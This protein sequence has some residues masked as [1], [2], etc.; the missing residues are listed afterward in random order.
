MIIT[1]FCCRVVVVIT[2]TVGFMRVN[3]F[4][5]F[6]WCCN[7]VA[8]FFC[9][10]IVQNP[11]AYYNCSVPFCFF[12]F[13]DKIC[14][15][16]SVTLERTRTFQVNWNLLHWNSKSKENKKKKRE[17]KQN[18][19]CWISGLTWWLVDCS[20]RGVDGWVVCLVFR[21]CL[22][23]SIQFGVCFRIWNPEA[24]RSFRKWR[25]NRERNQILWCRD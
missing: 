3:V 17:K 18:N 9:R 16:Y 20:V 25:T 21:R 8:H 22:D 11:F 10:C 2:F 23:I 6:W 5:V 13:L 14:L 15:L 24:D 7:G 4:F 19:A 12:T 1:L